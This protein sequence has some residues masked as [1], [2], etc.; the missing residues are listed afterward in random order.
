MNPS[1]PKRQK[2]AARK[3]IRELFGNVFQKLALPVQFFQFIRPQPQ[4]LQLRYSSDLAA[5]SVNKPAGIM[6]AI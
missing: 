3:M 2:T 4:S 6:V 5:N 1:D